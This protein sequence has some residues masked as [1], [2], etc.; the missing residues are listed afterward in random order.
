[1]ILF[2]PLGFILGAL[3]ILFIIE[4]N[5][6]VAL[7]FFGYEFESSVALV[8]ILALLVGIVFTL[9]MS[10]PGIIG[11]MM[12]VARLRKENKRLREEAESYKHTAQ[13]AAERLNRDFVPS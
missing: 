6:I 11:N 12:Q 2:L 3:A 7:S 5:A 1:M 8:V 9:F 13:A 4:N 10:I